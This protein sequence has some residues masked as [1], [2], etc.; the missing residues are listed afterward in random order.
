M[1]QCSGCKKIKVLTKFSI[2]KSKK[3]TG[4]NSRCKR[5]L[6][7]YA[8]K[9]TYKNPEKKIKYQILQ[10]I[11][12]KKQF[13]FVRAYKKKPCIDC[14]KEYPYYVMQ[15]DH[16]GVKPKISTI[17]KMMRQLP[18]MEKLIAEIEKCEL[19]CANCHAIRTFKRLNAGMRE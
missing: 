1:K 3:W 8:L 17:S 13:E 18:S 15:F 19:V 9:Y 10:N 7:D 11:K 2:R 16:L 6:A 14:Q 5:C 4:Y 12:R